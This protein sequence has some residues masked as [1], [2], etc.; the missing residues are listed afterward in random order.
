MFEYTY[1]TLRNIDIFLYLK[2]K[3]IHKAD[4]PYSIMYH[5]IPSI[6]KMQL[7]I[8][9]VAGGERTRDKNEPEL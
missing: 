5:L 4:L 6:Y 8:R 2:L 3:I 1:W 9:K 7:C